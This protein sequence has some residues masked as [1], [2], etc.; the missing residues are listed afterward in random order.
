MYDTALYG[1]DDATR[2]HTLQHYGEDRTSC[3]GCGSTSLDTSLHKYAVD[4]K[5]RGVPHEYLHVVC[6]SCGFETHVPLTCGDPLCVQCAAWRQRKYQRRLT[7]I[8]KGVYQ[9]GRRLRMLTLTVKNG[10][11]LAE[12]YAH[13]RDCF[14]RLRRRNVW[15]RN[16]KGAVAGYEV[17]NSGNGWH[18]HVHVFYD[19]RYIP[20]RELAGVWRSI[21]RDSGIVDIRAIHDVHGAIREVAK[22]PFKPKD[23]ASWSERM[24]HEYRSVMHGKRL[25]TQYGAWYGVKLIE[26]GPG[27][28]PVC[29]SRLT[30]LAFVGPLAHDVL[31]GLEYLRDR[32]PP[33]NAVSGSARVC[34]AGPPY[35]AGL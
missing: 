20:Q 14:T 18:V 28:C 33:P 3:N 22:Y 26:H 1:F 24:K 31:T 34:G 17:T 13:L 15:T 4:T 2:S 23:S 32:G 12:R 27:C 30:V 10:P 6:L 29:D 9:A 21:T 19:G 35:E 7:K 11:D 8:I 5:A 16:V 25:Y